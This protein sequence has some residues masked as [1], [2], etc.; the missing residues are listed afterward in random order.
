MSSRVL[1]KAESAEAAGDAS[2]AVAVG[3]AAAA[4]LLLRHLGPLLHLLSVVACGKVRQGTKT[5]YLPYTTLYTTHHVIYHIRCYIRRYIPISLYIPRYKPHTTLSTT[6]Y[7]IGTFVPEG[8][9]LGIGE[10]VHGVTHFFE[11]DLCGPLRLG[12]GR[13]L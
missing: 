11:L 1:L 2:V 9:L 4:A 8:L 13:G 7:K 3:M 5:L 12:D 6:L 10:K